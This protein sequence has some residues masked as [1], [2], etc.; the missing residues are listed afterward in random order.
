MLQCTRNQL[1]SSPDQACLR[2]R[3]CQP[4][5]V[6]YMSS[7]GSMARS[8]RFEFRGGW[9]SNGAC[10]IA[11]Q[12]ATLANHHQEAIIQYDTARACASRL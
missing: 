11:L 1:D 9:N 4:S 10:M 12:H 7:S 3:S 8:I 6:L 2:M 5:H